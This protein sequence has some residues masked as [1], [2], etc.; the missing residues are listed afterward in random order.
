[1]YPVFSLIADTRKPLYGHHTSSTPARVDFRRNFKEW[2]LQ[3]EPR[4]GTRK[5]CIARSSALHLNSTRHANGLSEAVTC[6]LYYF[7][8]KRPDECVCFPIYND[9]VT[10][11]STTV[12]GAYRFLETT[13]VFYPPAQVVESCLLAAATQGPPTACSSRSSNCPQS[14]EVVRREPRILGGFPYCP[15][16]G[17]EARQHLPVRTA[18]PGDYYNTRT[19][20]D[21]S[22]TNTWGPLPTDSH[23][24]REKNKE[25]SLCQNDMCMWGFLKPWESPTVRVVTVTSAGVKLFASVTESIN[26]TTPHWGFLAPTGKEAEKKQ[27]KKSKISKTG[28]TTTTSTKFQSKKPKSSPS[29]SSA[30]FQVCKDELDCRKYCDKRIKAPMKHMMTLLVGGGGFT[31]FAVLAML[32]K[33]Y[34]RHLRRWRR[35]RNEGHTSAET[36]AQYLIDSQSMHGTELMQDPSVQPR[37]RAKVRFQ[38]AD[39]DSAADLPDGPDHALMRMAGDEVRS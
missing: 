38:E 19:T 16:P 24:E 22:S 35:A 12:N 2:V 28:K 26:I 33:I 10:E 27:S 17:L 5:D 4:I 25:K 36:D 3:L 30:P 39:T 34:G 8:P 11:S 21:T 18:R 37:V 13:S 1:M 6:D 32:L 31:A 9:Y 29:L 7:H 20:A 23:C 14:V 15:T